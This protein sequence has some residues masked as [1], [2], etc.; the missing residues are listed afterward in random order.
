M[1]QIKTKHIFQN[2]WSHEDPKEKENRYGQ[3]N[4]H[5]IL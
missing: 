5:K 1:Q 2:L 3:K 4:I